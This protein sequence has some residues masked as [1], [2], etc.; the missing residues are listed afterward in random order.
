MSIGKGEDMNPTIAEMNRAFANSF[1]KP[2][3]FRGVDIESE[4]LESGMDYDADGLY[5]RLSASGYLD[6]TD[7][8]G[9]FATLEECADCLMDNYAD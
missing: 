8:H 2:Q 5:C 6:C 1:M 9:P 7:W 3:A 4:I